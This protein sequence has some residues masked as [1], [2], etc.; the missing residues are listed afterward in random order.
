MN[1][2]V[3]KKRTRAALSFIGL[4]VIGVN[5]YL[6][7]YNLRTP[8][9]SNRFFV[10]TFVIGINNVVA[11]VFSGILGLGYVGLVVSW[12]TYLRTTCIYD[13]TRYTYVIRWLLRL[14]RK[15]ITI[16]KEPQLIL[17]C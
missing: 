3:L 8:L 2:Y 17:H 5:M 15:Q 16:M 6:T 11:Y 13:I 4:V 10:A 12:F 14:A 9:I 7:A 1:T